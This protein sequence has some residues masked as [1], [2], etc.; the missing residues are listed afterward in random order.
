MLPPPQ[1]EACHLAASHWRGFSD[2]VNVDRSSRGSLAALVLVLRTAVRSS[3]RSSVV[4]AAM[5][6]TSAGIAIAVLS[7]ADRVESSYDE[8]LQSTDAPDAMLYCAR[9]GTQADHSQFIE[10]VQSDP[11][12]ADASALYDVYPILRTTAGELVGPFDSECETG[13]GELSAS[14]ADW[15]RSG[16]PPVR[17][18]RGRLPAAGAGNEIALPAITADRVGL[19]VGDQLVMSGV[20]HHEIPDFEPKSLTVVGIFVGFV[21]VRPPGQAEYF[22]LALVDAA[23]GSAVGVEHQPGG[24]TLWLEPGATVDDLAAATSSSIFVDLDKHAKL[25]RDRLRPDATALRIL[26]GLGMLAA[27]AVLGQL[28]ARHLQLVAGDHAMLRALGTTRLEGWCLGIGHGVL[29]GLGAASVSVAVAAGA[30][31]LM[32]LGAGESVLVGAG[33]PNPL[34]AIALGA[35]VTVSVVV[36]LSIVPAWLAARSPRP[37][38]ASRRRSVVSRLVGDGRFGTTPAWGVRFAL[39]PAGGS[40]PV[41]VRSGLGAAVIAT[42]VVA[43][44]VTF[45]GG[46]DHLRATPRLVGWNWDFAAG[47][48]DVDLEA[49]SRFATGHPGVERASLGTLF[50]SGLSVGR[51]LDREVIDL[52]FAT[53]PNAV[54]ATVVRGR[55]PEGPD[56]LLIS[57]ALANE[58]GVHVGDSVTILAN[59]FYA[60]L[61]DDLGVARD[62][63]DLREVPFELVGIG[64]L[65]IPDGRLD[66]GVSLTLDGLKRSFAAPPRD[67]LLRLLQLADPNHLQ[68]WL[69]D[70][71]HPE[72]AADF[73][74]ALPDATAA[75]VRGWTDDELALFSPQ[76]EPQA[77][78]VVLADDADRLSVIADFMNSGLISED[79]IVVG[80]LPDGSSLT[81]LELV[82]LDLDDVAWIPAGMGILMAATSLAV[83]A[84]LIATGVRA[85]RADLATLRALGLVSFQSRMIIGWQALTLAVV[86]TAVAIPAGVIGGRFAWRRYAEGVGVVPEPVTPWVAMAVLTIGVLAAGL[87]ASVM[88]GRAAARRRPIESLRSE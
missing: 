24:V 7:T 37:K 60:F 31:P 27:V 16:L 51:G 80:V 42:A 87:L 49:L 65:P 5:F 86:T 81:S 58:L 38:H 50:P 79:S 44:V 12:V 35:V 83:L 70:N 62:L 17:L 67:D 64:V 6:G 29:I 75:V 71:D 74:A 33:R 9:C 1:R 18:G 52:A 28:L 59:D 22:E 56:E 8:L 13:S 68:S 36:I 4:L 73:E 10:D 39:E 84:H 40:Q 41:P 48:D 34:A 30:L 82:T 45:A 72:L 46:L 85:R 88:P 66:S 3:W 23:F 55:T 19:D 25:I 78:F 14:W 76:I 47:G 20:C 54:T 32:P 11:A 57:P 15:P 26:A 63:P 77:L 43:G 61:H 2:V 69:V 53:G 21:D